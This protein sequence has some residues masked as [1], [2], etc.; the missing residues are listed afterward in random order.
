MR[1]SSAPPGKRIL[2]PQS[3]FDKTAWSAGFDAG[4]RSLHAPETGANERDFSLRPTQGPCLK[5]LNRCL[6]FR[7]PT[8]PIP[9]AKVIRMEVQFKT[10]HSQQNVDTFALDS[11]RQSLRLHPFGNRRTY[12]RW[13][14]EKLQ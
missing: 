2:N 13:S 3:F 9:S 6:L 7:D 14:P 10:G 5:A 8:P 11:T 12:R 4:N 1:D